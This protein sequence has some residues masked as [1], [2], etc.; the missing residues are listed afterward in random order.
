MGGSITRNWILEDSPKGLTESPKD[1]SVI[2]PTDL[3]LTK[4]SPEVQRTF[5]DQPLQIHQEESQESVNQ[6]MKD[7]P[8]TGATSVT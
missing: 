4:D 8:L 2:K 1:H 7:Y 3:S 6:S 5:T